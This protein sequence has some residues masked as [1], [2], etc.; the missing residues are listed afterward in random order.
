MGRDQQ[1]GRGWVDDRL[2]PESSHGLGSGVV[3]ILPQDD[4]K[5]PP[6]A[7]TD[8]DA[9]HS[10]FAAQIAQQNIDGGMETNRRSDQKKQRRPRI[11]SEAGKVTEPGEFLPGMM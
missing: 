3:V 11:E 7:L 4:L 1:A 8:S 6:P 2:R 5:P 10:D 9:A